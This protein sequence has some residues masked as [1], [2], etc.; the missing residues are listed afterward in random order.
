MP[1]RFFSSP[2]SLSKQVISAF[3][4]PTGIKFS[5]IYPLHLLFWLF[6]LVQFYSIMMIV[7]Q[8]C[9][10]FLKLSI[11]M[12]RK[13]SMIII[14]GIILEIVSIRAFLYILKD[15]DVRQRRSLN[16][17]IGSRWWFHYAA[18]C[19]LQWHSIWIFY[20]LIKTLKSRLLENRLGAAKRDKQ[21][22]RKANGRDLK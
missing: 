14:F 13:S 18:L 16:L 20:Y 4:L 9:R 1:T 8:Q 19:S 6:W 3:S 5:L 15:E 10:T 17:H 2:L 12:R 11:Q 7:Q 21:H 22:H